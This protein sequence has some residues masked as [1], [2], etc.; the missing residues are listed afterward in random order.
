MVGAGDEAVVAPT[1]LGARVDLAGELGDGGVEPGDGGRGRSH[2][3]VR[4]VGE[5]SVGRRVEGGAAVLDRVGGPCLVGAGPLVRREVAGE[6]RRPGRPRR[7]PGRGV[8][9]G[10]G[11]LERLQAGAGAQPA[12]AQLVEGTAGGQRLGGGVFEPRAA[13]NS[14]IVEVIRAPSTSATSRSRPG[15][16]VG[17]TSPSGTPRRVRPTPGVGEHV[18]DPRQHLG[19]RRR[20][21]VEIGAGRSPLLGEPR[22]HV[23]EGGDVEEPFEHLAPVLGGRP[24]ERGELA[25]G[26]QHHL[27]ELRHAHAEGVLDDVGDLVVTRAERH[28]AA[29]GRSSSVTDGLHLRQAGAPLLGAVGTRASA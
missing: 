22:L 27:G 5:P 9:L 3:R 10:G 16:D 18:L 13:S 6:G 19:Q 29:P 25:L 1:P 21:P 12:R 17:C 2:G 20:A 7:R 4:Q 11:G 28:P 14:A 23:A 24:Q 26:Q 8:V 15:T